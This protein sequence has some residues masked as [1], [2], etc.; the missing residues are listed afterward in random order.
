VTSTPGLR[1]ALAWLVTE[2]GFRWGGGGLAYGALWLWQRAVP[3]EGQLAV[4]DATGLA[5]SAGTL[6]LMFDRRRRREGLSL[7][8]L[9][10]RFRWSTGASGVVCGVLML[11]AV[12]GAAAV[13]SRFFGLREDP[14]LAQGIREAGAWAVFPLLVGNTLLVPIA[15]ELAWRGYVQAHLA[16]AWRMPTAV[17]VTSV[18]F[19]AKH[20]VVD[21][22]YERVTILIVG[23][24]ALSVVRVR[25]GT[26]TSTVAHFV[27]NFMTSQLVIVQ[28]LTR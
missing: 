12:V 6:W 25:F 5:L 24:L 11:G 2:I 3:S 4:I 19:T 23:A 8:D 14:L 20:L 1:A 15:E 21:L 13:D 26:F 17:I 10:Y 27:V 18:L 7:D 9:G 16:R 28:A 22:S